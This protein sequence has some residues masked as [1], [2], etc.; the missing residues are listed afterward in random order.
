MAGTSLVSWNPPHVSDSLFSLAPFFFVYDLPFLFSPSRNANAN[1][2][3]VS[4]WGANQ[5][6]SKAATSVAQPHL[7]RSRQSRLDHKVTFELDVGSTTSPVQ[8][9]ESE[10]HGPENGESKKSLFVLGNFLDHWWLKVMYCTW[11]QALARHMKL[12]FWAEVYL[13]WIQR[14]FIYSVCI[15]LYWS[16]ATYG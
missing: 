7:T 16:Y 8:K 1:S 14:N 5:S 6:G 10:M 9:L 12:S 4:K 13:Y 2:R 11:I 15:V 3:Q